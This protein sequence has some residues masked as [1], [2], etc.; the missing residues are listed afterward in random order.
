MVGAHR[1][2]GFCFFA[3]G[4]SGVDVETVP[5]LFVSSSRDSCCSDIV[6]CFSGCAAMTCCLTFVF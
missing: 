4:D 2:L 5:L 6:S 1:Q 3:V